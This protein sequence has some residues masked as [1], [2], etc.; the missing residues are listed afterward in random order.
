M[1][2]LYLR[3]S[4]TGGLAV[5]DNESLSAYLA[6][7]PEV[8]KQL[9]FTKGIQSVPNCLPP[10]FYAPKP[11]AHVDPPPGKNVRPAWDGA[12]PNPLAN[13]PMP[14]VAGQVYTVNYKSVRRKT[15]K[16]EPS[17]SDLITGED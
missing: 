13:K 2:Q 12:P 4:E 15:L 14:V 8:L 16:T 11:N 3:D 7:H 9:G 5:A 1:K 10:P 6:E 17:K